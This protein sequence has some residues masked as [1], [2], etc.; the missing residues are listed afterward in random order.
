MM[1]NISLEQRPHAMIWRCWPW[2]V[3]IQSGSEWS[4]WHGVVWHFIHECKQPHIFWVPNIRD[5]TQSC[6]Q[7]NTIFSR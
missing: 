3:S 5:K 2:F 4:V 7:V 1:H 6:I